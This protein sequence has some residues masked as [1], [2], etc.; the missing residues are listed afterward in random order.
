MIKKYKL[1][2][3][4]TI[5]KF[6][7]WLSVNFKEDFEF[8]LSKHYYGSNDEDGKP[9][10]QNLYD[11]LNDYNKNVI[12]SNALEDFMSQDFTNVNPV[13]LFLEQHPDISMP[14]REYL[15]ALRHSEL[16]Y[17]EVVDVNR[18]VS[19][20]VQDLLRDMPPQLI[21]EVSGSQN[22]I[23]G[24]IIGSRVI[25]LGDDFY[26][27]GTI[28]PEVEEH[29]VSMAQMGVI[30]F[31]QNKKYLKDNGF[32]NKTPKDEI[33]KS[34]LKQMPATFT[35]SY[36]D[37]VFKFIKKGKKRVLS[38]SDGN[39]LIFC[40][41]S[42]VYNPKNRQ[43]IIDRLNTYPDLACTEDDSS[44]CWMGKSVKDIEKEAKKIKVNPA[45]SH[46][47]LVIFKRPGEEDRISRGDI[48]LKKKELVLNTVSKERNSDGELMIKDV[49]GD[50][51][52]YKG[53]KFE[54]MRG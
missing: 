28:I 26:F 21:L 11:K 46:A 14:H 12:I 22:V 54:N 8:F 37:T 36:I 45:A 4:D 19:I 32:T 31:F 40:S 10:D 3:I 38:D 23:N 27:T 15:L 29:T 5:S 24:S 44:W 6:Q 2:V 30:Y 52:T 43:A 18:G 53:T 47:H 39:I 7:N 48:G 33:I 1:D 20:T 41:T 13:E 34:V 17:Y 51:V 50:L 9:Y 42:F 16:S 25:K 49:L 35:W